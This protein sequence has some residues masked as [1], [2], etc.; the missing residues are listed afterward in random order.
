[1]LKVSDNNQ[2]EL[3]DNRNKTILAA[4]NE[5]KN[6]PPNVKHP[7]I[8]SIARDYDIP[9]ITLHR[10]IKNDS[11][12]KRQGPPTILTEHE[13][14]Q[15]V[16]YC[17]NMQ[18][19]GFGLTRSGVNHCVMEIMRCNK[20]PHPFGDNGPG[21]DWWRCFMKDH[22][23]LS[24]HVPQELSEAQAQRANAVI[25]KNHFDK[26]KQVINEHS[27][28]AMQIWNMDETG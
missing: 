25:V 1:M 20:R 14:S 10:A 13:E 12:P 23:K 26:L 22:P 24:F 11:P 5:Y 21:R 2:R 6:Y 9:R 19:L 8:S 27:L 18:K 16:G 28:T 17:I 3:K 7:S 4:L 15:L